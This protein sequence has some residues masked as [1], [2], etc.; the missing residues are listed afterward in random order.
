MLCTAGWFTGRERIKGLR[1]TCTA[2]EEEEWNNFS[3]HSKNL[4]TSNRQATPTCI[5]M[6]S[7]IGSFKALSRCLSRYSYLVASLEDS[8][9]GMQGRQQVTW[10]NDLLQ[11]FF[12]CQ[13]TVK[14]SQTITMPCPDDNLTLTVDASPT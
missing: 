13:E 7:F 11:Q 6:R 14:S 12:R 4:T 3:V 1:V 10:R 8:I 2:M 9:K 5:S